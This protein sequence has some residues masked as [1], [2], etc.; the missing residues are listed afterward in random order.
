MNAKAVKA[1]A[2]DI[3]LVE[4]DSAKAES[5]L[6]AAWKSGK[7][8][9]RIGITGPPGAGKSTLVNCLAAEFSN[10]NKRTAVISVDPSSPFTGGAILGDRIRMNALSSR[11]NVYIR[12][13]ATRGSLGGLSM[14]THDVCD[15]LD[16]QGFDI[17]LIETVG[18]GQIEL[19]IAQA[20][21][22]TVTVLVPESGDD[23]Q[24]MKA[25]IMEITDIFVVNKSDRHGAEAMAINLRS[26][27]KLRKNYS[28]LPWEQPVIK[29]VATEEVG[30][31][32]ILDKLEQ[33]KS[34]LKKH[35]NWESVRNERMKR[36][37]LQ[38]INESL[39]A[40]FWTKERKKYLNKELR[41]S[42]K[43]D[44]SPFRI[45]E[46]LLSSLRNT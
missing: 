45:A 36:K 26:L 20:A 38:L 33:F 14:K 39:S 46:N 1:L 17:I 16:G 19:D 8:A 29:T 7:H 5:L 12:S 28:A 11:E 32:I 4:N 18:V 37:V 3:S 23:I 22:V 34:M 31:D 35:D 13:M 2:R 6:D 25:G 10:M 27:T 9:Y 15:I 41:L 44:K 40:S 24:A 43:T 42:E 21:D 30:I